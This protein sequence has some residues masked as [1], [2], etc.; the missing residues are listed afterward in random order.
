MAAG[1]GIGWATA[2]GHIGATLP[3]WGLAALGVVWVVAG[4]VM[5]ASGLRD[6]ARRRA[7]QRRLAETGAAWHS[8]FAWDQSGATD[9]AGRSIAPLGASLI[10]ALFLVPLNHRAWMSDQAGPLEQLLV[11]ALDAALLLGL[12]NSVYLFLRASLY[13]DARLVFHGFPFWLGRE[14][15]VHFDPPRRLPDCEAVGAT[16]R[17]VEEAYER[18]RRRTRTVCYALFQEE[19]REPAEALTHGLRL[20]FAL[21]GA[22]VPGTNLAGRPATYW[23]LEIRIETTGID[24][25][26]RFLLP[27]YSSEVRPSQSISS[28]R[29]R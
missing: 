16:L 18:H 25:L 2:Q 26:G 5:T 20:V 17:C 27:V 7:S 22:G 12:G 3:W 10:F 4:L 23:E 6:L 24:Y 9:R 1:L 11:A 14:V 29:T 13:A 8:D 21:P 28:R 19:R 15:R